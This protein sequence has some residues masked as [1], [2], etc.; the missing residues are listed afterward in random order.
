[1]EGWVD[2]W[3][4]NFWIG[5]AYFNSSSDYFVPMSMPERDFSFGQKSGYFVFERKQFQ[6]VFSLDNFGFSPGLAPLA[7]ASSELA[8]LPGPSFHVED[9]VCVSLK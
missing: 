2:I 7:K 4:L 9:G 1:M 8:D 3:R 5:D 6:V